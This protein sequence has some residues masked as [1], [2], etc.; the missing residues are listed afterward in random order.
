VLLV[1]ISERGQYIA[2]RLIVVM[3]RID[4]MILLKVFIS[5]PFLA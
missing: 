4:V 2:P 3:R 5:A 1:D